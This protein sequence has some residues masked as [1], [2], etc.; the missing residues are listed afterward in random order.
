MPNPGLTERQIDQISA[1]LGSLRAT[2]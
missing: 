1:Y 2:K